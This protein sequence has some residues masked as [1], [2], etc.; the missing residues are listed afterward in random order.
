V[1]SPGID[2][3]IVYSPDSWAK[4]AK[5]ASKKAS[6]E[7]FKEKF[8]AGAELENKGYLKQYLTNEQLRH[9]YTQ[10][11]GGKINQGEYGASLIQTK[12]TKTKLEVQRKGKTYTRSNNPR[13][14]NNMSF[15]LKLAAR[16]KPKSKEYNRL[17]DVLVEQG[18][19][20]QAAVKKVQRIRK[21]W[22][23]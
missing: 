22:V 10:G 3:W 12:P 4:L 14:S 23:N 5:D 18:R 17:I 7:K 19:T 15:V 2:K 20:R 13:W 9:I 21:K 16:E 6:F 11:F 1:G 8:F